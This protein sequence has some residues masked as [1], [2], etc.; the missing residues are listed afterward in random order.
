MRVRRALSGNGTLSLLPLGIYVGLEKAAHGE[1][2]LVQMIGRE[3]EQKWGRTETY[4][5]KNI[6]GGEKMQKENSEI[7][8]KQ[9]GL[10]RKKTKGVRE[11]KERQKVGQVFYE[12][13]KAVKG[14]L[15][16]IPK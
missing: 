7:T 12:M 13:R 8:T 4:V 9:I 11:M 16:K 10:R 2:T 5:P 1:V 15:V 6:D 3:R 14:K